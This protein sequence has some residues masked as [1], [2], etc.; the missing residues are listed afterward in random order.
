MDENN[1]D[2]MIDAF[3]LDAAE[4][5]NIAASFRYDIEAGLRGDTHGRWVLSAS[6][7]RRALHRHFS[8]KKSQSEKG[9]A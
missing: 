2:H 6:P 9:L 1:L 4:L 3:S 7:D 5:H 8:T